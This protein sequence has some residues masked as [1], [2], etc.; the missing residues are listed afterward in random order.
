[1]SMRPAENWSFSIGPRFNRSRTEAQYVGTV[2]DATATATYGRLYVFA[3]I[4][5][6][7]VSMETRLNV[8]FS[9]DVSFEM[10]AQPFIATGDYGDLMQLRRPRVFEFDPYEG[11]GVSRTDFNNQ[12]LRGNAVFRWEWRPGSTLFLVWQQRRTD[13]R[14]GGDFSLGRDARALFDTRP[15]NVFLVKLNYWLN[16]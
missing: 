4:E 3:P 12:S 8:N 13:S 11:D 9:P 15:S 1:M 2:D 5:Q 6:S 10:Y 16:L 14:E 7:T